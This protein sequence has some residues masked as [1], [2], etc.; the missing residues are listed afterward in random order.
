M[1]DRAATPKLW[2]KR[3]VIFKSLEPVSVLRDIAL[4]RGLNL[5]VG[6]QASNLALLHNPMAMAGH[7]V[8]KTTFCRLLRY[9]LTEA[10]FATQAGEQRIRASLPFS[11]VGAEV[12]VEG[13]T[14]AVIR[15]LGEKD[16]PS[17]AQENATIEDC[18]SS[19][20]YGKGFSEYRASLNNLLPVFVRHPEVTYHWEHLLAWLTR[21]Q[22]CRLRKFEVW[23]DSDS[24]SG[25]T[26]FRKP[27]EYPIYLV[28]SMLDLIVPEE[29]EWSQKLTD[30][31]KH[32]KQCTEN[33]STAL[34]E[35]DFAYREASKYL[36]EFIGDIADTRKDKQLTFDSPL[37]RYEKCKSELEDKYR[38]LEKKFDEVE[39]KLIH[40]RLYVENA[41]NVK[42]THEALRA[43]TPPPSESLNHSA[44]FPAEQNKQKLKD[45]NA[46]IAENV[47]CPLANHLPLTKCTHIASYIEELNK[48]TPI[49]QL[50]Q[51][52]REQ[53]IQQMPPAEQERARLIINSLEESKNNLNAAKQY[54][55]M[56]EAERRNIM[57]Q[58]ASTDR[59]IDR[60]T[61]AFKALKQAEE[62]ST[63]LSHGTEIQKHKE[64]L[65]KLDAEIFHAK[66]QLD[67]YR[68]QSSKKN[69]NIQKLFDELVQR[70]LKANYSGR[71]DTSAETFLPQILH[72][73][74]NDGAAIESLSFTLMDIAAA[75]GLSMGIGWHPGFLLH[76]SPR[77]ADLSIGAYYSLLTE[78]ALIT[79]ENGGEESA[80]FQY[81]I[82]TTTEPPKELCDYVRLS[83]AA[84]PAEEMLLK[85]Q[86]EKQA[87]LFE[88]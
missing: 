15:P 6:K 71:L 8:G 23:R 76:D 42:K 55:E 74:V 40:A 64:E 69:E 27:K 4:K 75:L 17:S 12:E 84:Y 36:A 44:W 11:W 35:A 56:Y 33:Y 78:L 19:E 88:G 86:I 81:I 18:L 82:T 3:L 41:E 43:G 22:E 26:G 70:V 85:Q 5:I 48:V 37:Q 29:S 1:F 73:N 21:D 66:N 80:P 53:A 9:C 51:A 77:E 7:S 20:Q 16:A 39:K 10:H 30:L 72:G 31:L 65:E 38:K 2:V 50:G 60:L 47:D 45:L 24:G 14:W 68:G 58:L 32:K 63:G 13:V 87:E 57:Q 67:F 25:T 28:R 79:Q 49:I 52:L 83:L 34:Q 62:W 61:R 59:E 54:A 46:E